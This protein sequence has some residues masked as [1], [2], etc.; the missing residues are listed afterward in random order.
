MEATKKRITPEEMLAW[1][2]RSQERKKEKQLQFQK[3]CESGKVDE[4]IRSGKPANR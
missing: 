1:F 3:D 4:I 2:L